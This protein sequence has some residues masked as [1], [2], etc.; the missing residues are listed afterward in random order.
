MKNVSAKIA[1]NNINAT[2]MIKARRLYLWKNVPDFNIRE[3]LSSQNRKL[4]KFQPVIWQVA[5]VQ[6]KAGVYFASQCHVDL[7]SSVYGFRAVL[8]DHVS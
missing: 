1:T 5:S 4:A 8:H 2:T 6:L 3:K 7:L